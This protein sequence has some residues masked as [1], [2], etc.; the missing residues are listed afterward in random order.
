MKNAGYKYFLAAGAII[1]IFAITSCHNNPA[2]PQKFAD[3]ALYTDN[4]TW[5]A[6][7]SAVQ[8]LARWAGYTVKDVGQG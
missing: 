7:V 2:A 3:I 4:G 1:F 8:N 6:S 5:D